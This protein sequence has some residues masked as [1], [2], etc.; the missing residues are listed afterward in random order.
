[1][2]PVLIQQEWQYYLAVEKTM[3]VSSEQASNRFAENTRTSMR[4]GWTHV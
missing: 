3:A 1:M 2:K 4:K